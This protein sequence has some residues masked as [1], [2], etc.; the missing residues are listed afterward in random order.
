ML[1][2]FLPV[3]FLP[4]GQLEGCGQG[5][6]AR[7]RLPAHQLRAELG[8]KIL[9]RGEVLQLERLQR[10]GRRVDLAVLAV[11]PP[12]ILVE[13]AVSPTPLLELRKGN[14]P[15]DMK[16]SAFPTHYQA[17]QFKEGFSLS[18]FDVDRHMN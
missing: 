4:P 3:V 16:Q 17:V 13:A 6:E 7:A 12:Q 9:V 11:D 5:D 18:A 2:L 14:R 15:T 8:W 10:L 1:S